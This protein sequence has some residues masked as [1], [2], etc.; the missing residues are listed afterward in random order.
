MNLVRKGNTPFCELRSEFEDLFITLSNALLQLG[1]LL[2][3]KLDCRLVGFA[4]FC[5]K[6]IIR[7]K[8]GALILQALHPMLQECLLRQTDGRVKGNL[9]TFHRRDK[10]IKS[11]ENQSPNR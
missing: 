8:G 5:Q 2:V 1:Q 9:R 11:I 6:M 4:P 7:L 3:T 10:V